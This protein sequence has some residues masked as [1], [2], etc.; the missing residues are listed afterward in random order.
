[1]APKADIIVVAMDFNRPGFTISDALQY[2]IT[3]SQLLNKPVVINAS[4]G[5]YYGSHDGSD[6]ETQLING[7]ISNVP[8]RA[9]VAA[10]GNAGRVKF[11]VGYNVINTDTNFTWIKNNL[12][13]ISFSEYADTSQIKNVMYSVGVTHPNF[14]DVGATTFKPYD[15]ALNTVKRDTIYRNSNRIGIIESIASINSYGVYELSVSINADSL[16]YLWSIAHTGIGRIDSWNFDY[17]T[18]NLPSASSYPKITKYKIADTLQTIVSGFQCS[19][20]VIA[21]GNYINRNRYIDVNGNTQIKAETPGQLHESS[22]TGPTRDN[23]I[24]PDIA[25]TGA[26]IMA[27]LPL[28]LLATYIASSSIVVAQGG[29][30]RTAG[31]TS[32]ASPVVAGLAALYFQRNPTATNQQLKQAIINCAYS[33]FYTGANL[34]SNRWG[35]G[36]LDGF[37]TM[38]CG[39]VL[40][41][42]KILSNQET[43]QAFPNPLSNETNLIFPNSESKKI[44][45]YNSSGQMVME[46]SC[47]SINYILKRNLLASGLYFILVEEKNVSYK[48]KIVIL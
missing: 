11:H 30:H 3:K 9:L 32:A 24:K 29:Y 33:D 19:D 17:V 8:G 43:I 14:T 18:T 21:V 44:K 10:C 16:N 48:I 27:A 36:K 34:P 42:I 46:D 28:S 13:T 47:E 31:G 7:L 40:D 2:I 38:T 6:L 4:L 35:Y 37:A 41:N 26:N 22:S 45:L 15:Y 12:N 20:E 1:M 23:R 25:A 5:D 39:E